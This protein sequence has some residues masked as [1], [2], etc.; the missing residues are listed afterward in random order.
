MSRRSRGPRT[1]TILIVLGAFCLALAPLLHWFVLPRLERTPADIDTT[2]VTM[3][4]GQYFDGTGLKGPI[5]FTITTRVIG[6]VEAGA[7]HDV[8]VWD[9]STQVDNP[10]TLAFADPRYSLQWIVERIVADPHTN[11]PV[12]CCGESP[13]HQ[14]TAFLKF[15]FNVQKVAYQYWNPF[16]R[17]AFPV[18]YSGDVVLEGHTFYRFTGK[19]PATVSGSLDLPG[20]L[21]GMPQQPGMV[22]LDTYYRDD[23][24]EVLVD[25]LSGAPVSTVQHV[26]TTARLPGGSD[27]LL[28]LSTFAVAP[29][30][31]AVHDNVQTAIANDRALNLIGTT[32]PLLLLVLGPVLL[33]IGIILL[34]RASRRARRAQPLPPVREPV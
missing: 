9:M 8:L 25:P 26:V 13:A 23:G 20:S 27:D 16:V 15:P 3:A 31:Q 7:G 24:I 5:Q 11:E 21:V 28:T 10:D 14:G 6:D 34:V 4:T 22:H 30:S 19:V 2:N 32:G 18:V 12:H 17:K 29:S 1:G 33:I